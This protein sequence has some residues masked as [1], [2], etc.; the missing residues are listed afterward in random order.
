[1]AAARAGAVLDIN[2]HLVARQMRRQRTMVAGRRLGARLAH[3]ASSSSDG[4]LAGL[5]GGD[6]L[7]QLL[8][9]ELQLVGGQLLGAAT[10]LM[11]GQALDQQ[12]HLVVLSGKFALLQQHCPQHQ[13]QGGGIVRQGVRV[14]LHTAMMD[15]AA[16][17]GPSVFRVDR[18]FLARQFRP[19]HRHP[20]PPLAAVEQRG[21]LGRGQGDAAG[22]R[23]RRPDEL[24]LLQPLGQHAQANPVMPYQFDQPG[25]AAPERKHGAV[26]RIGG[27]T[28]LHQHRQSGHALAHVGHPAGQVD[29]NAGRERDH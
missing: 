18:G 6:G 21:Q 15:G 17:P 13:L 1:M 27:Q 11:A 4:V 12:P 23:G 2:H 19:P 3:Q 26:E 22:G 8:Q 20:S 10:E 28:L 24:A 29:P 16:A 7:L 25:A 5:V 14:D 9:G